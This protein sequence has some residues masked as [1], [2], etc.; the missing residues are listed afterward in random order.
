M[1]TMVA[2]SVALRPI[3]S[4]KWPNR[5]APTGRAR[6]ATPKVRK[7]LSAWACGADCGKERL[8]DHQRRG[9][10]V[11]V[12]IIKFDRRADQARQ[13]DAADADLR[14]ADRRRRGP[15]SPVMTFP[16][17]SFAFIRL[18][19]TGAALAQRQFAFD[20][21]EREIVFAAAVPLV[22][23]LPGR[24]QRRLVPQHQAKVNAHD[25]RERRHPFH[26]PTPPEGDRR[27]APAQRER[28]WESANRE[29]HNRA[30]DPA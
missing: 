10:A 15:V 8:A 29:R 1:T 13:H 4:P 16:R 5:N 19:P 18:R 24:D 9:G 11:D 23:G 22:G 6:K 12:K 20:D 26:W 7:A 14:R 30:F 25:Q 17:P 3:R 27:L 21:A 2:T 28:P